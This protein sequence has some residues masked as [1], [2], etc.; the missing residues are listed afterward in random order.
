MNP[1]LYGIATLQPVVEALCQ[2]FRIISLDPRGTGDSDPIPDSY[3]LMEHAEDLRAIIE[4]AGTRQV[5]GVGISRGASILLN[6]VASYPSLLKNI[7]TIG[8]GLG[9]A[10]YDG[11]LDSDERLPAA[12]V[13][14]EFVEAMQKKDIEGMLSIFL[15]RVFSEPGT[16][17]LL[18]DRFHNL[19]QLPPETI[20]RFFAKDP[21]RYVVPLLDRIEI[22]TLVIHGVEDRLIPLECALY[23]AKHI[24]RAHL[25]PFE[26]RGHIPSVTATG[27]FCEVLRQFVRNGEV[28]SGPGAGDEPKAADA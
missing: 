13:V 15:S 7:V 3:S 4:A 19:L 1:V 10:H 27:E 11:S 22:P 8:A 5:T 9:S 2:E 20:F 14:P 25:Y 17:Q 6:L 26:G 12:V 18:K 21:H 16:E 24:P 28:P 23:L